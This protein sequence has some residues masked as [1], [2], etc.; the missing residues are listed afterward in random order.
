MRVYGDKTQD[1][2]TAGQK[3]GFEYYVKCKRPANDELATKLLQ[4]GNSLGS[5]EA[6]RSQ[7]DD[8]R[9]EL[10]KYGGSLWTLRYAEEG[11]G[12]MWGLI[13]VGAYAGR[14]DFMETFIRT[15][16][17]PGRR[18]PL[19]RKRVSANL[20]RIRRWLTSPNRKPW[21]DTD[22]PND[23]VTN[24]QLYRDTLR[25]TNETL[26]HLQDILK[27][28]PDAAADRLA[29]RMA[30]ETKDALADSP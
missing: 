13:S 12:T 24:K 25:V 5:Y 21:T 8:V 19:A 16:A 26:A 14:E 17:S 11:G 1:Y 15:L 10:N 20:E 29:A 28:L 22:D 3:M 27:D 18:S 7:I 9:E 6:L 4:P 23:V 2:S 30:E